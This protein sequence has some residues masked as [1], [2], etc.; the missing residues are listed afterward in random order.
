MNINI[1]EEQASPLEITIKRR[2]VTDR[3]H[4]LKS[5]IEL[6][7]TQIQGK[8]QGDTC[9]VN[10]WEI[11]YF[12]TVEP[13]PAGQRG[14]FLLLLCPPCTIGLSSLQTTKNRFSK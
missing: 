2:K 13:Y 1:I 8:Y 11:L 10:I 5:H 7:D 14:I 4:R 3:I 9:L 12:E 6:F